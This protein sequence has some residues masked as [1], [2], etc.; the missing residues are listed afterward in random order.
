GSCQLKR[1]FRRLLQSYHRTIPLS[2]LRASEAKDAPRVHG[3]DQYRR[4]CRSRTNEV[5]L[6]FYAFLL[7]LTAHTGS[8]CFASAPSGSPVARAHRVQ[9]TAQAM[10]QREAGSATLRH[11]IATARA[12]G[13]SHCS[14]ETGF[15]EYFRPLRAL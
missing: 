9:H 6:A 11:I 15:C 12:T 4:G 3:G 2:D 1:P 5:R 13:M 10:H 7:A 8:M 14:L